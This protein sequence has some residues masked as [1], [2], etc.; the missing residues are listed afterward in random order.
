MHKLICAFY[1]P[2]INLQRLIAGFQGRMLTLALLAILT[3]CAPE[4]ERENEVD[5]IDE[6]FDVQGLLEQTEARLR[7]RGVILEKKGEFSGEVEAS[8][9]LLDS[10]ALAEELDVFREVDINKPV[11]S[12]R[13]LERKEMEE[14]MEVTIYEADDKEELNIHY[15]KIYRQPENEAIVR[16]E[17]LFSSRNVLYN[18][19]RMLRLNYG[20][21]D[22]AGPLPLSYYVEG[23]QKMIFND[24]ESYTIKAEFHYPESESQLKSEVAP[25]ES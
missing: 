18:S 15:L 19:T 21:V 7:Q 14:G 1:Y 20:L 17:A 11:L 10:A 8:T 4:E 3:A 12:G 2:A 16:I 22:G 24:K 23:L 13:Y 25:A 5:R 6:Y 9:I